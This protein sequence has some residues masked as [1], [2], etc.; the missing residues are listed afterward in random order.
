MK[1]ST[2]IITIVGTF[3]V[4]FLIGSYVINSYLL[5]E[6]YKSHTEKTYK[7]RT[8]NHNNNCFIITNDAMPFSVEY[9][10]TLRYSNNEFDKEK[11]NPIIN[12]ITRKFF[13]EYSSKE[14]QEKEDLILKDLYGR[15]N[16][17]IH[18]L[19]PSGFCLMQLKI[20]PYIK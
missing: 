17:C 9:A 5:I 13:N 8:I 3:I 7:P 6:R 18:V 10:W 16:D 19:Y 12:K 4:G 20:I 14:I 11:I 2:I 1:K 15:I